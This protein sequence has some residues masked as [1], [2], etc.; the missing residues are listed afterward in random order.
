LRVDKA[1]GTAAAK[2]LLQA[3]H[4]EIKGGIF[5]IIESMPEA[6]AVEGIDNEQDKLNI[7]TAVVAIDYNR[8]ADLLWKWARSLYDD[9]NTRWVFNFNMVK[10]T[11]RADL[12]KA[13]QSKGKLRYGNKDV[14]WWYDN[15]L[16]LSNEFNGN[17]KSL[18]E[19]CEWDVFD[20]RDMLEEFYFYGLKGPKIFPLWIRMLRDI[21][22]YEFKYFDKLPIPVDVHIARASF[23]TGLIRG[24]YQGK[25]SKNIKELI[26][27]QW[28]E[29]CSKAGINHMD[30][31]EPLWHLSK[32]GCSFRH[33]GGYTDCLRSGNC[34]IRELCPKG[35][36]RV[37]NSGIQIDT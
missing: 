35:I 31:D 1:A 28:K 26:Q 13:L 12:S 2:I 27:N 17:P 19:R 21:L 3:Y 37:S 11:T 29:M 15:A 10:S 4:G 34:P 16:I 14:N 36:I 7:I 5:G 33:K 32:L 18:F 24:Q 6:N 25:L 22:D 23:T 30:L 20:I 9:T 8:P